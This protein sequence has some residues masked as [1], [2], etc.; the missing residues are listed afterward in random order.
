MKATTGL[1]FG[2]DPEFAAGYEKDGQLNI[3][4][5][6]FLRT[7]R[8]VPVEDNGRHP[9]FAHYGDTIVHEDGAAFEMSTPPSA[10]WKT[11]FNSLAYAKEQF[12]KDVLS[13]FGED[14]NPELYSIPAMR[15]DVDRWLSRGPEWDMAVMFGCDQ[16]QDVYN[17]KAKHTV[18]DASMHEWRY[19]GGHI[20]ASGLEEIQSSPLI[21]IRCMVITAGL[22]ATAFTDVPDLEKERLFLY[23]RPGKFRIQNYPA[24]GTGIEYRTPSTRWTSNI[25]LAEKIF[26]WARVGLETLLRDKLFNEIAEEVEKPAVKA[27]LKV[28]QKEALNLLNYISSKV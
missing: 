13:K 17:M 25:E 6:V 2:A 11:I 24:G 8:G 26:S 20:H 1:V 7:E 3:L 4:P 10:D 22:A 15:Y 27:I 5:P 18:L 21:A 23:G 28:D 9:I 12:A 14:C 19:M 16:D